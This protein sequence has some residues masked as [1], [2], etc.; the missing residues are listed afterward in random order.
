MIMA[1]RMKIIKYPVLS[2]V[3]LCMMPLLSDCRHYGYKNYGIA[4]IFFT[5]DNL[6]PFIISV[7]YVD[8]DPLSF[9][10]LSNTYARDKHK[11]FDWGETFDGVDGATC[12]LLIDEHDNNYILDSINVYCNSFKLEGRDPATFRVVKDYLTEDKYD[13]YW[14]NKPLNVKDKKSFVL[15]NDPE[16][17]EQYYWAKDKYYAYQLGSAHR[18]QIADY[19]S[20]RPLSA[21]YAL[22]K[23]QVYNTK[24]VVKDAK[25]GTFKLPAWGAQFNEYYYGDSITEQK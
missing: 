1:R 25:P 11:V 20:F 14:Y 5:R 7:K 10:E 2:L 13:Y 9:E 17:S 21:Y 18:I 24:G 12:R 8:A 19:S 16:D 23:S 22:D 6:L 15:L 4:V 3:C